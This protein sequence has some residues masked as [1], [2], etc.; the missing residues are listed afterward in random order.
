M[1]VQPDT[2]R[3]LPSS[4]LIFALM[5]EYCFNIDFH[6]KPSMTFTPEVTLCSHD[7]ENEEGPNPRVP[8]LQMGKS[9]P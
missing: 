1:S 8:I 9:T 4:I 7:S 3:L 5:L 6:P 2:H